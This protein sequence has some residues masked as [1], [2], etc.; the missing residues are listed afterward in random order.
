[1]KKGKNEL[2][3]SAEVT[4]KK[5]KMLIGILNI[6]E[7]NNESG[8]TWGLFVAQSGRGRRG[9]RVEG[10]AGFARKKKTPFSQGSERGLKVVL[11]YGLESQEH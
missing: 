9:C 10:G 2:N 6:K 4:K 7:R 1:M 8:R 3:E 11:E 5:K